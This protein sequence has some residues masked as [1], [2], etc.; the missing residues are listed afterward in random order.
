MLAALKLEE[1][2]HLQ[3]YEKCWIPSNPEPGTYGTPATR[4]ALQGQGLR[5][6]GG[7]RR[8]TEGHWVG[9]TLKNGGRLQTFQINQWE[10]LI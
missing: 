4:R 6:G 1:F 7:E 3:N 2:L 9:W 8:C 5:L 10:V